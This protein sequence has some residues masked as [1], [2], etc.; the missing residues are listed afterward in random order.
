MRS[1]IT[2]S[3][4]FIDFNL[5]IIEYL[6]EIEVLPFD[7]VFNLLFNFFSNLNFNSSMAFE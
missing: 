4:Q 1:Q 7:R 5:S 6:N 2:V 3:G